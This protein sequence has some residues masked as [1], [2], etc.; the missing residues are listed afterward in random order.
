MEKRK[1]RNDSLI[2]SMAIANK[3][4]PYYTY[5]DWIEW[6]GKWELIEGIRYAM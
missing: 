3:I 5:D 4:L 6:E 1:S 2:S